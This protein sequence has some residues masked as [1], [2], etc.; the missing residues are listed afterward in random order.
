M[1]DGVPQKMESFGFPRPNTHTVLY[2]ELVQK[3]CNNVQCVTFFWNHPKFGYFLMEEYLYGPTF[4]T[5][6]A[7]D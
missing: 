3:I 1:R 7:V 2:T 6:S 4:E 5:I